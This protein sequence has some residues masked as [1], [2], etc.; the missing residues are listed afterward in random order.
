[1]TFKI[2]QE[3]AFHDQNGI[4]QFLHLIVASFVVGEDLTDVVDQPLHLV[5]MPGFLPSHYQGH[6][7]DLGGCHYVEEEG[8]VWF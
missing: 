2:V 4:K 6:A 7:N 1:V 5:G 3:L 8:L